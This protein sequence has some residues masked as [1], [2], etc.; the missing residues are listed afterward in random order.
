MIVDKEYRFNGHGLATRKT[1]HTDGA[2]EV[3]VTMDESGG[4]RKVT[5]MTQRKNPSF[6]DPAHVIPTVDYQLL[7]IVINL[8]RQDKIQSFRYFIE[9]YEPDAAE[10]DQSCVDN[11]K[12]RHDVD[13]HVL[14]ETID[15]TR[16]KRVDEDCHSLGP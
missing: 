15:G 5:D 10:C 11:S 3:Y 8:I 16:S 7:S 1:K 4:L 2:P 12:F 9:T 14:L 13:R 6:G